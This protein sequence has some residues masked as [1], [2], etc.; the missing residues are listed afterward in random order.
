MLWRA[1]SILA[2]DVF[3]A[4]LEKLGETY[5]LKFP[6]GCGPGLRMWAG[7]FWRSMVS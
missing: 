5:N 7:V 1:A 2:R 4:R 3:L 6:K